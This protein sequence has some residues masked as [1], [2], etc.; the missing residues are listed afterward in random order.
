[1]IGPSHTVHVIHVNRH[2]ANKRWPGKLQAFWDW[3]ATQCRGC[4]VMM[5]DFSLQLFNVVPELRSRGVII[6]LAAWFPWKRGD[7]TQ[8]ADSCAIFFLNRPGQY[9][10]TKGLSDLHSNDA[11]GI[12]FSSVEAAL[13]AADQ[14]AVAVFTANGLGTPPCELP[15]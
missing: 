2:L 10:L 12:L 8:C 5:G 14:T 13:T 3:L 6:D 1:M 9:T 11:S 4:D 15:R 7:G